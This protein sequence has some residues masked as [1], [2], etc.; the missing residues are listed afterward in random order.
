MKRFVI[1]MLLVAAVAASCTRGERPTGELAVP[2]VDYSGLEP[3]LNKSNDT[4]Y[5]VNFWATWCTPCVEELPYLEKLSR[6]Y[7]NGP[8][9]VLLVNLDFPKYYDSRLLPFLK[10]HD[11][12]A[13]V[14]MLDDSDTNTWINKI[15]PEWQGSIP[16]TVIYRGTKR[17]FFER[18][19][20]YEEL[21]EIVE[22]F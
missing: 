4:T 19:F 6:E 9:K 11:I 15:S 10:E 1:Y 13:Q 12:T 16:A 3:Y 7:S 5:I 14:I 22:E 2:I 21:V 8:V 18:A 17:Q 20:T